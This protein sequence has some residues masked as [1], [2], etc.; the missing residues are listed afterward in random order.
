M[1]TSCRCFALKAVIATGTDSIFS[2][3]LPATTNISL[4][5][6][7]SLV[8][9]AP[10]PGSAALAV[11]APRA[12]TTESADAAQSCNRVPNSPSPVPFDQVGWRHP[13][14]RATTR[15]AALSLA[16]R[17]LVAVRAKSIADTPDDQFR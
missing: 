7:G 3:R 1:P 8:G 10:P 12:T 13:A 6:D 9:A 14:L 2:S 16:W 4:T 11:T 5:E 15:V 17:A